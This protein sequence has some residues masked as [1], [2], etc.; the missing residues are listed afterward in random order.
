MVVNR[1]TYRETKLQYFNNLETSKNSKPF[2]DKCRPYLSKKHAQGDCKT[3]LIEKEEIMTTTN[4]IV[5]KET[6]LVNNDE[7][8][9]TFNKHFAE[10][11]E[12]LN[13]FDWPSNKEESLKNSKTVQVL[14]K[15]KITT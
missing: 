15:L 1:E 6:L 10:T 8:A 9:K 5:E 12:K 3:I 4:E 13:T 11:A 7:V 2:W 14:P